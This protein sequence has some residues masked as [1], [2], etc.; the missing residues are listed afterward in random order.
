MLHGSF[1]DGTMFI[2]QRVSIPHMRRLIIGCRIRY[3]RPT[4]MERLRLTGAPYWVQLVLPE[5]SVSKA[6]G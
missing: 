6:G 2:C 1:E 3:T 4:L 5:A